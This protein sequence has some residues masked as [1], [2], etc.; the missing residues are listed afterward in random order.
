MDFFDEIEKGF[1]IFD[2]PL[3]IFTYFLVTPQNVNQDHFFE[4][5]AVLATPLLFLL[6]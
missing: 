4:L 6:W 1:Q 2:V 5:P 3:A